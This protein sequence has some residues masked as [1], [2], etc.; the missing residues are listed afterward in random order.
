MDKRI[1]KIFIIILLLL[2]HFQVF[3]QN[4]QKIKKLSSPVEFD[5]RPFEDA[6]NDPGLFPLVVNSPNFG[7]T[8]S[9]NSEVMITYDNEYLWIGARLYTKD[10]STIVATSKKRDEQSQTSDAFGIILDTENDN[11]NALAFFTMPTGARIDFSISNDASITPGGAGGGPGSSGP[12]SPPPFINMNWNTFWDVK[13]ARDDKGWY[14]EMR[15]PF[16]SIRFR[17]KNGIVTMGLIINRSI[18][19]YNEYDTYPAIDPKYGMMAAIKPSLAVKIE[20]EG[21]K[22]SKPVYISPYVLGGFSRDWS[23]NNDGT[24]YIRNDKPDLNAG[25]DI[26]YSINSNLTL[27]LT[28]N[29]DFAQVEAD[30]QQV[31]LT[32]YSLFFPEKRAF[33][34]ERSGLFSYDLG[35]SSNLFYSRNIG[36]SN[37]TPIKILGGARLVGRIGKWDIGLLN[38]QT[39][40]LPDSSYSGEN[41]TVFRM[42][43]QV[44]NP[45][46]FVGGIFTSRLGMNGRQNYVYGVDGIFRL[47]DNDYLGLKLAQTYDDSINNRLASIDPVFL[48]LNWERRTQKGFAYNLAY[49]Y[50]GKQ[51]DPG[52][53]FVQKPG[54]GGIDAMF[55]YGWL[56]G[57]KS[58]YF[59]FGPNVQASRYTRLTD[60]NL[61]SMLIAPGWQWYTKKGFG[62]QLSLTY[63]EEGVRNAFS[64]S[65]SVAIKPG[66]YSFIKFQGMLMTP[67]TK[68]TSCNLMVSAGQFYDGQNYSISLMPLFNFSSSLQLS[69]MYSFSAIR[70]PNRVVY[71]KL[72]IHSANVSALYMF[73]TKISASVLIQYV[74]TEHNLITNFRFRYNPREG[75]DFYLVFNETRESG[76][77]NNVVPA[78]PDYYDRTIMLKYTHTFQLKF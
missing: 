1:S 74:S 11:E 19:H 3:G 49:T 55:N 12:P 42:R 5:G 41:F 27:D 6:W 60:G 73:S 34:Q 32:R 30:N 53:G 16:S 72:N 59:S 10:V 54:L 68:P 48:R 14:V 13:T 21:I 24:K 71:N 33:F 46:S 35:N 70:F 4:V 20:F 29:T 26:K 45:N 76:S 63:D 61:E 23:L 67:M 40:N 31:N 69:G 66:K 50:S 58:T 9:E 17:P 65:D 18:S 64:L 75:N 47:Y 44:I 62:G 56:P 78:L 43:R 77:T 8:P 36:M 22:T 38:M 7:N 39:G 2:V 28:A 25:L 51:F 15:I 37:G 57:E 52:I